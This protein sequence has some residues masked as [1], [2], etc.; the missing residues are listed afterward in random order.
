VK[1]KLKKPRRDEKRRRKAPVIS[2]R[3]EISYCTVR[4]KISSR[5]QKNWLL[6]VVE[7]N[8]PEPELQ[9][10]EL[11]CLAA[12]Q[13]ED[14]SIVAGG[15]GEFKIL[16]SETCGLVEHDILLLLFENVAGHVRSYRPC[17]ILLGSLRILERR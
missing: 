10:L 14:R 13:T 16:S 17:C 5:L 2:C 8:I 11:L 7:Y 12:L 15:G 4:A 1:K 6:T 3:T 9:Q